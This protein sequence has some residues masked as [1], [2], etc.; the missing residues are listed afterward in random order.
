M[1]SDPL[2]HRQ[3]MTRFS[4]FLPP[5][6]LFSF[7]PRL[8]RAFFYFFSFFLWVRVPGRRRP[9]QHYVT[10][11]MVA[12]ITASETLRIGNCEPEKCKGWQWVHVD[13]LLECK[14]FIPLRHFV[15][16]GGGKML[17]KITQ[18]SNTSSKKLNTM[19]L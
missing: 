17:K 3:P 5:F 18:A 12:A 1:L 14:I 13:S 9:S 2:G 8:F 19:S 7:F 10:V 4:V 15:E 11:Y 16:E 6:W